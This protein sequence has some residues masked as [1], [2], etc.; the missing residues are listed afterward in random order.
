MEFLQ[1]TSPNGNSVIAVT[2]YVDLEGKPGVAVF[3]KKG[4]EGLVEGSLDGAPA[5]VIKLGEGSTG[6][7]PWNFG[8][9]LV[10]AWEKVKKLAAEKA[11]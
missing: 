3:V 1:A 2:A 8:H 11:R 5:F 10:E 4:S 7:A 9:E 6:N